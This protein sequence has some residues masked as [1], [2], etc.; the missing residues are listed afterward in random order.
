MKLTKQPTACGN[1]A[2]A[3]RISLMQRPQ[4]EMRVQ[5]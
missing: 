1:N 2:S 5:P 3:G 4:H